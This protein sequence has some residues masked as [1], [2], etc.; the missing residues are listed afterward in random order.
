VLLVCSLVGLFLPSRLGAGAWQFRSPPVFS[1]YCGVG[2]LCVN[3]L[4]G[5]VGVLP[6]LDGFSCLVCLQHLSKIFTL[7]NTH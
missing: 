5:G 7:R 4:C 1:V 6:L 2:K 3:W